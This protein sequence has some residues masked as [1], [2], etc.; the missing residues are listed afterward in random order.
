MR[1]PL[2]TEMRASV[3]RQAGEVVVENRPVP[4]PASDEVLVRVG[5]VGICGSDVHYFKEGRIG[6]FVVESPLVLGHEAGGVIV[7]V[8]ADVDPA[9]VG[10][11]V[12]IEPQRPSPT[13]KQTMSGAYNLC[14]HMEFYATPPIDGAFAEYVTIQSHFAF[15]VPENISDDAAA[16]MEPLSVGIAAARKA[17]ITAGSRVLV[18]GAGPIGIIALQVARAFGATEVIVSDLDAERRAQALAFGADRVLDAIADDAELRG[19]GMDVLLECSGATPA[20]RAG[21]EALAPAGVAVL[22]GMGADEIALPIPLIQ[23]RELV[24]TGIFRYNNTWPTAI[25]LVRTGRVD[26]DGLVTGGFGLDEVEAALLAS[27]A[28]I[29]L[30]TM[31]RP[32][33]G[34]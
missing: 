11:R 1:E 13:S 25:D 33:N 3:L 4:V 8:G 32:G 12:S 15:A 10:E 30:K 20:V 16:L 9:R 18:T 27:T 29:S 22:V 21:L 2:P 31:I 26:L 14:P 7:A 6:D 34:A 23:N 19:L 28:S 24:V 17:G 5:S